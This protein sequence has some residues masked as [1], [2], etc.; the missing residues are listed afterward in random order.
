MKLI[1][2]IVLCLAI[3]F[4]EGSTAATFGEV[5]QIDAGDLNV[6]YVE[7]GPANGPAVILMHGFPYDIHSYVD[8]TPLLAAK[9][10]RVVVPYFRGHGTTTFRSKH[11]PRTS[12][13]SAF[14]L[15]IIALMD[16]LKI[17][18]AVLA[19]FDWGSRTGDIIAALW[20]ERV[21]ALVSVSGYLITN[22]VGNLQPL[23]PHAEWAWWYQYYFA[24]KRGE[25]GLTNPQYRHDL[26]DVIWKF[27][28]PTWNY[29]AETYNQTAAAFT[30]EDY[31]AIVIGNYRWRQSLVKTIP[32]F[33]ALEK[34][35]AAAPTIGVPTI[36][37]DPALDPFTAAGNG[38]A[39]R[40]KF[41]G[42]YEHRVVQVGHNLPQE[43]PE[44]FAQAVI[45]VDQF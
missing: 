29:S 25:L 37:L 30:N 10:Y 33:A 20:P 24:T 16:A 17:E 7:A 28:S 5:K 22:L 42:K 13:Q 4:G 21:K 36:T 39:Y 3:I 26:G 34:K 44:A 45:D 38:S 9:G 11:T 31:V 27:N 32:R 18:K 12:E 6:G 41:T 23:P 35:L 2:F 1:V 19:G 8:V 40:A 43:A 14:A 15:D